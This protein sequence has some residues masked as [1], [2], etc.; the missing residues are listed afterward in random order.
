MNDDRELD[1]AFAAHVDGALEEAYRRH[2]AALQAAAR[3]VLGVAGDA[4]DCVHD[5]LVRVWSKEGAYRP[6]RG[7]LRAFLIV[8][9]RNEAIARKRSAGRHLASEQRAATVPAFGID[10][11]ERVAIRSALAALPREQRDVI[12]LAYWGDYTQAEIASRLGIPLGTI[13]S[14]AALGLRKLARTLNPR[15]F[16]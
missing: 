9:V 14:R 1:A 11:A 13:K 4:R 16:Q 12:E 10:V 15:D 6:E 7:A 3:H 2:S 8:C 5:A